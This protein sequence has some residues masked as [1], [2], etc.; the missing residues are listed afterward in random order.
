MVIGIIV[1]MFLSIILTKN[2]LVFIPKY[3]SIKRNGKALDS[4]LVDM[5]K[6][7]YLNGTPVVKIFVEGKEKEVQL[8]SRYFSVI[9]T[10]SKIGKK[11]PVYYLKQEKELCVHN[12]KHQLLFIVIVLVIVYSGLIFFCF[13]YFFC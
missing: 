7:N 4:T 1:T 5:L 11:I 8:V 2:A 12:F 6:I 10:M 3:L 9:S 13:K